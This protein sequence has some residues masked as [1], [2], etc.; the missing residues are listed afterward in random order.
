MEEGRSRR[1]REGEDLEGEGKKKVWD[2]DG[3]E[4]RVKRDTKLY[5]G[6]GKEERKEGINN[7]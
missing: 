4:G 5:E 3:R 6:E 7:E 1:K 2:E